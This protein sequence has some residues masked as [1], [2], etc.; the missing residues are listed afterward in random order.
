MPR[1]GRSHD[2][3]QRRKKLLKSAKGYFGG[4]RK[5][6]TVAKHAVEKGLQYSFRD[7]RAKKREFRRLW[8]VRINA[9][10]RLHDL[11]YSRFMNGL[12]RAGVEIDR[13]VLS[14]LAVTDPEAFANLAGIAK[15]HLETNAA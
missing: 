7:R 10:A 9:A 8:I 5:L 3:R 4:R 14:D 12:K 13:S 6:Y 15:E 1:A 11:S 2:S